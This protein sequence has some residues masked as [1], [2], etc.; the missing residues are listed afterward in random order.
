MGVDFAII[1]EPP[2]VSVAD[3]SNADIDAF[4]RE[5]SPPGSP[6]LDAI[7]DH[8]AHA[9]AMARSTGPDPIEALHAQFVDEFGRHRAWLN[10]N[11]TT[12]AARLGVTPL[13]HFQVEPPRWC[14]ASDGVRSLQA[15]R[16]FSSEAHPEDGEQ[17]ACLELAEQILTLAAYAGRRWRLVVMW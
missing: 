2:T 15:L 14:E 12:A 6:P 16:S 5:H 17:I 8:V 1:V 11:L 7:R 10:P 4:Y 9:I 13:A 3:V